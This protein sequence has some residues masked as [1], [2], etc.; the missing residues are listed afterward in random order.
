[1]KKLVIIILGFHVLA[2]QSSK[3][4]LTR[5][6]FESKI[7]HV[8]KSNRASKTLA[9]GWYQTASFENDFMR[10][11]KTA[12]RYF[13]NPKPVVLPDNF[14]RAKEYKNYQ[15]T[16]GLAVYFDDIGTE[17][18]AKATA[19]NIRAN[20]IFILDN[21]ILAAPFVNSQI[22]NGVS[23]FS[24]GGMTEAQWNKIKSMIK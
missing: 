9:D 24:K 23:A 7:Q 20:L 21:E 19:D 16:E 12:K 15:G 10:T 14:I 1:M 18:W 22:T 8:E 6:E 3:P 4:G 17:A 11:D 2:C 5:E 13:I